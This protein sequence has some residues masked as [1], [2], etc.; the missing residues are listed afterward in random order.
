SQQLQ[1]RG[2][3]RLRVL[4]I[5][6]HEQKRDG[7]TVAFVDAADGPEVDQSGSTRLRDDDIARMKVSVEDYL[8]EHLTHDHEKQV[9]SA[10]PAGELR[11]SV[12]DLGGVGHRSALDEVRDEDVLA[13][14]LPVHVRNVDDRVRMR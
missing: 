1:D 9:L 6:G 5:E 8:A 11:Q 12:D 14:Q 2:R 13:G 10:L 7:T 4:G 3:R